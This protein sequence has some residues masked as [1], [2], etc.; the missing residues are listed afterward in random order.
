MRAKTINEKFNKESDPVHD[1]G[2]GIEGLL[3]EIQKILKRIVKKY[4]LDTNVNFFDNYL[5]IGYSI[6]VYDIY[7]SILL[8]KNDNYSINVSVTHVVS[9][10]FDCHDLEEAEKVVEW[11]VKEILN[12]N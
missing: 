9:D 11:Q 7:V 5:Q 1:L 4:N 10:S 8:S 12:I 3:E 2:I 6:E